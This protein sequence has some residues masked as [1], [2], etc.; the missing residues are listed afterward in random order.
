MRMS[1]PS[2]SAGTPPA[3]P[4]WW[5]RCR[6]RSAATT[7]AVS[8][9]YHGSLEAVSDSARHGLRPI[10]SSAYEVA[11]RTD[12]LLV[13]LVV[14]PS[15]RIFQGLHPANLEGPRIP[16]AVVSGRRLLL[17][18]SVA[19]PPGYYSTQASGHVLCDGTYI[20]QSASQLTKAVR[21]WQR[22]LS[23]THQVGGLVVVH[24]AGG[25]PHLLPAST[26]ELAWARAS[27]AVDAIRVRLIR[28]RQRVSRRAVSALAAAT[29]H[30]D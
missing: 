7:A 17:I 20:G 4:G 12:A 23:H 5:G 9:R 10:G 18:E 2:T 21:H 27:D 19:W 22:M 14:I 24:P 29:R 26:T 13:E 16:H 3:R 8:R 11:A 6:Q 15:V 1:D 30:S 25:D 28:R